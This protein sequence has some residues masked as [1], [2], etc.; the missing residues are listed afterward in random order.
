M[1]GFYESDLERIIMQSDRD[2]L[3]ERGL[4]IGRSSRLYN[5]LRIGNYGVADIVEVERGRVPLGSYLDITIYEL[6][7]DKI[8]ISAF[9]QAIRYAQGINRYLQHC[10]EFD[11]YK[12]HIVL[13]GNDLDK[14]GSF[15]F[16]GDLF[17]S[18]DIDSPYS[19]GVESI[20][21]FKYTY[22][23]DGIKFEHASGHQLSIEGF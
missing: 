18:P 7:K 16:L 10:R 11:E 13:I 21:F 8:G 12:L 20:S 22:E 6:K 3:C 14:T 5:Q 1:E 23:I 4:P 15:C 17:T 9:L 2:A 19:N